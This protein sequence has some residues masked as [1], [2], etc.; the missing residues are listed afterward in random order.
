MGHDY[1]PFSRDH[2]FY[3]P[4]GVWML[5]FVIIYSEGMILRNLLL[6]RAAN[7]SLKP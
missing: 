6:C 3:L 1:T 2:L 7:T 4:Q 5:K